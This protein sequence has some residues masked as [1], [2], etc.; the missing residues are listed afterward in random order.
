[1]TQNPQSMKGSI[2]NFNYEM[3]NFFM[4]NQLAKS[5]HKVKPEKNTYIG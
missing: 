1:M 3:K 4:K 2:T 5:K